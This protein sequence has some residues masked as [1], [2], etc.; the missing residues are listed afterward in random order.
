L[1]EL[2]IVINNYMAINN[3]KNLTEEEALELLKMYNDK[4]LEYPLE[5]DNN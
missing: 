2:N 1:S 4:A 5:E 3:K